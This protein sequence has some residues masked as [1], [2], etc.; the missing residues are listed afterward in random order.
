MKNLKNNKAFSLPELLVSLIIMSIIILTI[1]SISGMANKTYGSLTNESQLYND[2]SY[3][4]KLMQS[5]AR[6]ADTLSVDAASGS[7]VSQCVKVNSQKFG[8]YRNT[9][10]TPARREFSYDNGATREVI[11]YVPD[12]SNL[13]TTLDLA[14]TQNG[15][16]VTATISG[17][18]SDIPF[19]IST[20]VLRRSS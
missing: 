13:A 20:T 15:K 7:W 19:N 1:G 8:I 16:A 6:A 4:F 2:I 10:Y 5:K 11:F 17:T 12:P 18:K 14:V 3:G 9:T